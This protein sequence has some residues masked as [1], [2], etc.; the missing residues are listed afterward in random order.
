MERISL[1][2][3][4]RQQLM[5]QELG[6][7]TEREIHVIIGCGG[8][9]MWLGTMLCML[10][11]RYMVLMDG[12]TIDAS[13][14]SRLPVP[15]TWIGTNK[16]VALRKVIRTLRPDTVVTCLTTHITEDTLG[17][18]E[19]FTKDVDPQGVDRDRY[20]YGQQGRMAMN[21]W[22]TTDDARIQQ[23][24]SA[25]VEEMRKR[26]NTNVR[27]RKMGYDGFKIGSYK[28]MKTWALPATYTPGYRTTNANAVSSA[29]AA[30]FGIFGSYLNCPDV[31]VD[32]KALLEKGGGTNDN[33]VK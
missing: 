30:A 20:Y 9:G 13:N 31:N 4:S 2:D 12:D 27:Y 15:Q 8:I 32:V 21:V 29:I 6:V 22:D 24:I 25:Y 17:L 7:N 18:L 1:V 10:G 23:R 33:V 11:S 14:L 5:S 3:E 16:A 28:D 26:R 19:T